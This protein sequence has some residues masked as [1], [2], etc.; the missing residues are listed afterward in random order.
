MDGLQAVAHVYTQLLRYSWWP[1]SNWFIFT[2][3]LY[4]CTSFIRSLYL[5]V[6]FAH[7]LYILYCVKWRNGL[8]LDF[9]RFAKTTAKRCANCAVLL[10]LVAVHQLI[11]TALNRH[12]SHKHPQ[13]FKE[14]VNI[15]TAGGASKCSATN[16]IHILT[17]LNSSQNY[18]Y[19]VEWS[20]TTIRYT[21]INNL[22]D[23]LITTFC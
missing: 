14:V 15:R 4:S 23:D 7:R 11:R 3:C 10:Y 1:L 19:S 13:E 6:H 2:A 20:K 18:S 5:Y 17:R 12:L 8:H 9:L 16:A 21:P 22:P